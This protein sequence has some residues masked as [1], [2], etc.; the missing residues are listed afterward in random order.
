MTLL[1]RLTELNS[2]DHLQISAECRIYNISKIGTTSN[3][4]LYHLSI[5]GD[6]D[7]TTQFEEFKVPDNGYVYFKADLK[8]SE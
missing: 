5:F 3:E 7:Y 2:H 8:E 1:L 6:A 4:V